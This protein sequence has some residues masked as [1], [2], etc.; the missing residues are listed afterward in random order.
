MEGF[1]LNVWEGFIDLPFFI[2]A[3]FLLKVKSQF[4]SYTVKK[5][6]SLAQAG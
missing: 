6:N 1:Y 5:I 4:F 2:V 3:K